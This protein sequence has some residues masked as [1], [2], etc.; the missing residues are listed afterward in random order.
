VSDS[1][2]GLSYGVVAYLLWGFFPLF[3]PL[4]KP[5]KP[6]EI[7]A[8]R[9]VWSLVVVALILAVQRR[10]GWIG[11]LLHRPRRLALLA[12][13]AVLIA[14]NWAVFIY[15]VNSGQVVETSLGYFITPLVSVLLG[16]IVLHERL[17][18]VQWAAVATGTLAVAVLAI[19][20][21][22]L[23]WIA[24][25]LAGSFGTYGL[26]KKVVSM[27]AVQSLAVETAV[28]LVPALGY[29]AFIRGGTLGSGSAT[30]PALLVS[31][32]LVTTAPLLL[33][34]AAARR[35]PLTTLGLLQYLAPALQFVFGI[36][37]FHE[38]MPLPR[39]VG[40]GLV[41]LALAVLT[42]DGLGHRQDRMSRV[43]SRAQASVA[44]TAT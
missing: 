10:R 42:A 41:W 20:Y 35:L 29:L 33:F 2:R 27:D 34:G 3:W 30:H 32:G 7:L 24:L 36:A 21:G 17:R 31:T 14:I 22:H 11:E 1:R 12:C 26:I 39:L 44:N 40:F 25:V 43:V 18:A 16:V 15:G 19:T 5:A 9:M 6:L 38:S 8:E 4:L 23:P 13:A 28:L 37:L